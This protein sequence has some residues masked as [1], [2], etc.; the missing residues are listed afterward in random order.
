MD[1]ANGIIALDGCAEGR[2]LRQAR[3]DRQAASPVRHA[4]AVGSKSSMSK[5]LQGQTAKLFC[6]FPVF[7]LLKAQEQG[8]TVFPEL[9]SIGTGKYVIPVLRYI[10]VYQMP[11]F[12]KNKLE[13]VKEGLGMKNPFVEAS[14]ISGYV[15]CCSEII[16]QSLSL[17]EYLLGHKSEVRLAS[18]DSIS[19]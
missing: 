4:I 12:G 11:E 6:L 3:T 18:L 5:H 10:C 2:V 9:F 7:S 17:V 15:C 8:Q 16:K 13:R 19:H 1:R 14:L